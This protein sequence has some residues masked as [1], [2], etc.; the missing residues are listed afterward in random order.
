MFT[1]NDLTFALTGHTIPQMDITISATVIDSR[2]AIESSLF[3]AL[4]G[5]KVN[6]HDFVGAAFDNG[7]IAAIIDQ[8]MPQELNVLDLREGHFN[9]TKIQVQLPICLRVE[10]SLKALQVFA[11]YWR[12]KHPVTTI[13][14]TGS[15]GKTTTKE[16]IAMVLSQKFNVLKNPGNR[17][18]EIGLPLTLLELEPQHEVAVLEMG[19]YV[20]GEITLL[21]EIAQPS[22]GVITNIGTVHAERVGSQA[23]IAQG[24][25]ELVQALPP[26]PDGFAILNMDDP[27]VRKMAAKTKAEVLSYGI[28]EDAD[29]TATDIKTLGLDGLSC[30]INYQGNSCPISSHL[31][32]EFSV[33]TILRATA[34]A[35]C[36]GMT[37]DQIQLGISKSH[38]QLRM[39]S[40]K[41]ADD[42]ALINDT[43]NASPASTIAALGFLKSLPGRRVAILGDM[44]ELGQYEQSGHQ[45]VGDF[46]PEAVDFVILVGERSQMIAQSARAKGF[47]EK[48]LI[49]FPDSDQAAQP[50]VN[51]LEPGDVI[52]IKGSNSMRMHTILDAIRARYTWQTPQ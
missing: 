16:L 20:L 27:W 7:A 14:I 18:N 8:S 30:T 37:W 29:L 9:P 22:I 49:W 12:V 21:C 45:S 51:V 28:Y 5:E 38:I 1:I 40:E 6:G 41:L 52:L 43:Y 32:G 4:P 36:L 11:A 33:Y 26:K 47:T 50:A 23:I 46:L 10:N 35:L 31:L 39:Q 48:N 3:I 13:G 42:M 17:N 19:F 25:A 2:N 15:V 44:L 34:V 24:K